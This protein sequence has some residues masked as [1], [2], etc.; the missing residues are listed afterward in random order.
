MSQED[1]EYLNQV[2][3]HLGYFG[4]Y[5]PNRLVLLGD[6]GKRQGDEFEGLGH[7]GKWIT[8]VR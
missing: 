5:P 3:K 7:L 4:V 2:E 1:R 6:Y 8:E